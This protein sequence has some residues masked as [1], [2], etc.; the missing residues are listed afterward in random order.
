MA[1]RLHRRFSGPVQR[2]E[3]C[4]RSAVIL[5]CCLRSLLLV[6]LMVGVAW[7]GNRRVL[8]LS[9]Y[10]PAFPTFFQQVEGIRSVLAPADV[11]L[12]VEFMD[13]K[14]FTDEQGTTNFENYLTYKLSRLP[15]YDVVITSDDNALTFVMERHA[16]LFGKTPVVF[17]GVNNVGLARS[18]S[19]S[20]T[21]TG[22]I[23]AVS[24]L[25]T[26]ELVWRLK[27]HTQRLHVVSDSM[28]PGKA[29]L[30]TFREVLRQLPSV[31]YAVLSLEDMGW[32]EFG[33]SLQR[34]GRDDAVL[35]LSAYKDRHGTVK[36]FEEGLAFILQHTNAPVYHLWE[37][38]MGRGLLGG[39]LI[40]HHEQGRLAA[41]LALK[42]MAGATPASLAVIEGDDANGYVFDHDMLQRHGISKRQLPP[43]STIINE[44]YS[45][46]QTYWRELVVAL[47]FMGILCILVAI[48]LKHVLRLREA[49]AEV[50]RSETR[51]RLVF[52]Q[53]PLGV[54]QYDGNGVIIDVN[55]RFAEL[56]GAPR[57]QII[58]FNYLKQ[59]HDP[60][61]L[62]AVL[63]SLRGE[64]GGFEG[65]YTSPLGQ[66]TA[67]VRCLF[68][69]VKAPEGD[70][71]I[72]IGIIEDVSDRKQAEEALRER[73]LFLLE[74]QRIAKIGG[75]KANIRSDY[76]FW[77]DEVNRILDLPEDYKPGLAEG[78]TYY[79]PEY[80]PQIRAMLVDILQHG[81]T[82]DIECEAITRSGIRKWTHLRAVGRV[83]EGD[84]ALVVGTFQDVDERKRT[85]LELVEAKTRAIA[86]NHAK[87]EFLANMSH[88]IRTPLSGIFGMLKMLSDGSLAPQQ[89]EL[90]EMAMRSCRRLAS[91]LTDVL[92]ISRIEAGKLELA[93]NPFDF[94]HALQ[95]VKELFVPAAMQAGVSLQVDIDPAVPD[96]VV[97]DA[98]R[99]QQV[100]TN[101]IGNAFKFT[102]KGHI[103]LRVEHLT[104]VSPN[105]CRLLFSV[106]DT[107][108]GIPDDKHGKLFK[109][110]TQA[111]EGFR[112]S[113]QGAGLGLSIC[114]RII[115]L[116]G[117]HL[118]FESETGK[119]TTMYFSLSF[120]LPSD[121]AA[122]HDAAVPPPADAI[123]PLRVLVTE[124]DAVT[125]RYISYQ[126]D[127][128]GHTVTIA[129]DGQQALKHLAEGDFDVVLMDIQMPVMD[130]TEAILRIRNGEAGGRNVGI[131]VIALTAYA[132][133]GDRERLLKIG[134]DDY[135]AKPAEVAQ[136]HAAIARHVPRM[137]SRRAEG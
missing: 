84:E 72:G 94:A 26:V 36:T 75:W 71:F 58:G 115:L 28:P 38:G 63:A 34:V 45:V 39:K 89:Q 13:S 29:D 23:E 124:D 25:E 70:I 92:D 119:G 35:L 48:L 54:V 9:S 62:N 132:L 118:A 49:R 40:S 97:G 50:K 66:K 108:C 131:P 14:R 95:Q 22:V 27:P 90:A 83:D 78:L 47:S 91:L 113:H 64:I 117:G 133:A 19:G 134:A 109:P 88:E 65:V 37:H 24:M 33:A 41:G 42:I 136:L 43:Q 6:L 86:A 123:P 51:Y 137:Q 116:M 77:S 2:P 85:E 76:L 12:D 46:W 135:V 103:L 7:A 105:S 79:A 56:C 96:R 52:D 81:G 93:S 128:D 61:M 82:A 8:L 53:S 21:Y 100:L 69:G 80:L 121:L 18:L 60:R 32:D 98:A 111:C 5:K 112:R 1:D 129:E 125:R 73:E 114:R 110:F 17:C 30:V 68:K 101:L 67:F 122:H 31:R 74:T 107:G 10:A 11:T 102:E 59:M 99:L 4:R 106:E 126:L 127:R 87:D 57:Q 16:R 44:P 3:A 120:G 104:P 20:A 55:E 15:S 130:G